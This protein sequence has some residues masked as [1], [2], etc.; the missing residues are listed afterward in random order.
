M[1]IA[2]T[3][4]LFYFKRLLWDHGWII[5]LQPSHDT[6]PTPI[7]YG[8]A[9]SPI[10]IP[11]CNTSYRAP[12]LMLVPPTNFLNCTLGLVNSVWVMSIVLR[13]NSIQPHFLLL[14]ILGR[15]TWVTLMHVIPSWVMAH[16]PR[17]GMDAPFYII[18]V[19]TTLPARPLAGPHILDKGPL[20]MSL[21]LVW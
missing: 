4:K 6:S 21:H 11:Q 1:I 20:T 3:Y 9:L 12:L 13:L 14:Q 7:R 18:S 5:S 8:M 10:L 16:R 17:I 19:V 2:I 15:S